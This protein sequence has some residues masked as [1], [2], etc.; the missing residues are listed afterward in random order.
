MNEIARTLKMKIMRLKDVMACTGLGRSSIY[1]FIAAGTFPKP[2]ALGD[3]AVGWLE[4]EIKDWIA[5]KIAA[6]DA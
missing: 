4:T 5:S 1:K 2:I 3:R 6:R